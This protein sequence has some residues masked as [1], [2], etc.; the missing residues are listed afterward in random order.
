MQGTL[1]GAVTPLLLIAPI[2]LCGCKKEPTVAGLPNIVI[3]CVESIRADHLGC[4]G[5]DRDTSPAIDSLAAA[6]VLWTN[7]QSQA[8][9]TLPAMATLWTG[10]SPLAHQAG[11]ADSAY[12][13]IDAKLP[14]IPSILAARGYTTAVFAGSGF[15]GLR[16]GFDREVG[17]F[18]PLSEGNGLATY[19]TDKAMAWLDSNVVAEDRFLLILHLAD[20][21]PPYEPQEPWRSMWAEGLPDSASTWWTLSGDTLADL[22][23]L[24]TLVALYDGEIR[25]T[26]DQIGRL[27]AHLRSSGLADSTVVIVTSSHGEELLDHGWVGN[28][29]SLHRELLHVP[30]VMCGPGI[31]AG[32]RR[33]EAVGLWDVLPTVAALAGLE[34]PMNV[35][36]MDLFSDSL[37]S[38]RV[39][40]SSGLLPGLFATD[41]DGSPLLTTPSTAAVQRGDL[42]LIRDSVTDSTVLYDLAS[43]PLE[44]IPLPP[45]DELAEALETY[46]ATPPQ[47]TAKPL[48]DEPFRNPVFH[49]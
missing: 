17:C 36:G 30:L 27:C 13:P 25:T 37:P 35:E 21:H 11:W 38:A 28:G 41:E 2:L 5:Y 49:I 15:T 33:D 32:E 44:T 22:S 10:L 31:P 23:Q 19:C 7:C 29:H 42:K 40:P 9:W 47:G 46:L 20:P 6:G 8:P 26:D 24:D 14:S 12:Q 18:S 45:V 1:R 3:V 4:F 39:I 34:I 16:F 48:L 43:D